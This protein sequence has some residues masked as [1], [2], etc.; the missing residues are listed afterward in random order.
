MRMILFFLLNLSV[1]SIL[2]AEEANQ[3]LFNRTPEMLKVEAPNAA[4]FNKYIDNPI[5]LYNGTPEVNVPLYTL[6]DGSIEIPITLRYNTS[7]IKVNEEA[8][9]VG[10]GWNLN[11]GGVITRQPVGGIDRQPARGSETY[12]ADKNFNAILDIYDPERNRRPT[13]FITTPWSHTMRE[14]FDWFLREPSMR[15]VQDE[16]RLSPD[17]FY[18]SYPGGTGK[19][20]IDQRND[21]LYMLDR[22][23]DIKIESV[24]ERQSPPISVTPDAKGI[25]EFI[26]TL[27]N[28][29]VHYFDYFNDVL[30]SGTD[31][32]PLSE[33]YVLVRTTYPDGQKV[34]YTYGSF[35]HYSFNHSE[36]IQSGDNRTAKRLDSTL[37]QADLQKSYGDQQLTIGAGREFVLAGISTDNYQVIFEHSN[38]EDLPDVKKLD[39]ILVTNDEKV[40]K[41]IGFDYDY[42]QSRAD[43]ENWSDKIQ[44]SILNSKRTIG[45]FTKRLKL[46][47]V[48]TM[49][50][51]EKLEDKYSFF[52]ESKELPRK[53]S[54]ATDYWGY[55]NGQIN[56]RS[57]IPEVYDLMWHN[58]TNYEI[59]KNMP[60]DNGTQLPFAQRGYD[61][62]YCRAGILTGIQ[63]P[64]GGYTEFV[65]EPNTFVDYII[66]T[67]EQSQDKMGRFRKQ[68]K[69]NNSSQT[70]PDVRVW[71][72]TFEKDTYVTA[73][74]RV[75]RGDNSW[76]SVIGHQASISGSGSIDLTLNAQ[77]KAMQEDWDKYH[78]NKGYSVSKTETIL[79]KKGTVYFVVNFPDGLGNQTE[80]GKGGEITMDISF[81]I[82][83]DDKMENQG[84][85]LRIKE[86]VF[87]ES[88][89][90]EQVLQQTGYEYINP[91]TNKSSG[92]LQ[93]KLRF[94]NFYPHTVD[95][96]GFATA[97]YCGFPQVSKMI[98]L[99]DKF[100]IG[101]DNYLTTPYQS[102]SDVGYT[103]VKETQQANGESTGYTLYYFHNE[104][105]TTA[106][107]SISLHDPLNGK[108]RKVEYYSEWGKMVK[109]ETY[110]YVSDIY[111]Y[112]YGYT[113]YDRLNLFPNIFRG[114]AWATL[115][116][117]ETNESFFY[118]QCNNT[119]IYYQMKFNHPA[120]EGQYLHDR[121]ALNLYPLN[122][123][124]I[125]LK[126]K[127]TTQDGMTTKEV[128]AYN[129]ETLQLVEKRLVHPDEY[130]LTS[131][132]VY[133]NDVYGTVYQGM[134]RKHILSLIIEEKFFRNDSLIACKLQEY[135]EY[136]KDYKTSL[137]L[138]Y[139]T[140]FSEINSFLPKETLT[141]LGEGFI[142]KDI[143]P[144]DN[145]EYCKYD[146]YGNLIH[147]VLNKTVSY[148]YLWGY[149][150]QYPIAEISNTSYE[151]VQRAL[152]GQLPESLSSIASPD[153]TMLDL[154][155]E[156]LPQA[157]I[158]TYKY[159]PGIG[160]TEKISPAGHTT[161]YEY[162]GLGRMNRS[163]IK[164][165]DNNGIEQE[166]TLKALD[167]HYR[168]D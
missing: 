144:S 167:Y 41:N 59:I 136:P 39:R 168:E 88:P 5:G 103:C 153:F 98:Y 80:Y 8:S 126:Q 124:N 94:V 26:I 72:H 145:V 156:K 152:G 43:V 6:K 135:Q 9:W 60:S 79:V 132:Y 127:T 23:S 155:R 17:V 134:T 81:Q 139:K 57:Y 2:Y 12:N 32:R 38:R 24:L 65:Y 63:Y 78:I 125:T 92:I 154:L 110:D 89:A 84:A 166:Q 30:P 69:D 45:H 73:T 117:S 116:M 33:T 161:Y 31:S 86:L 101:D 141:F 133:P 97:T 118:R 55:Y 49:T 111:H 151:E 46:L 76:A 74:V 123:Y 160:M 27:P 4:S 56:N 121:L 112:Y 106:E 51:E 146:H 83:V 1:Y 34:R 47:S 100:E 77:C 147:V 131:T 90:K 48:Y 119:V 53:D 137:L 67:V 85:G 37:L 102:F 40:I 15:L 68:I 64:T 82:D 150:G 163:Y 157:H 120:V 35:M 159:D 42:F 61:F 91:D 122:A 96:L 44:S 52:Y 71:S 108:M 36:Q 25:V 109:S 7:G 130:E 22:E 58:S 11:V 21:S 20:I 165:K 19:F 129:P 75:Y 13:D 28:G 115:E 10:L 93:K 70:P 162:D 105:P 87:Y 142:N 50:E 99:S 149:G 164:V 104:E 62:E 66:P 16:G 14:A 113:F 114:S 128:Y 18:F 54:Y 158:T 148:V 95:A 107:H 138:P 140:H 29:M 143:Y 3:Y